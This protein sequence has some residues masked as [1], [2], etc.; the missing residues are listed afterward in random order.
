MAHHNK[1]NKY[2][3]LEHSFEK[4]L[5]RSYDRNNKF[6]PPSLNSPSVRSPAKFRSP[7]RSSEFS[8]YENR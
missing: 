2:N 8:P 7:P 5:Q 6:S 1:E 3:Y 4:E